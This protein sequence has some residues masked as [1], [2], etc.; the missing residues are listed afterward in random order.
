MKIQL[1]YADLAVET[2]LIGEKINETDVDHKKFAINRYI[3][4]YIS[5][6]ETT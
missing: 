4:Q 2:S 6:H 1:S 5:F 3:V